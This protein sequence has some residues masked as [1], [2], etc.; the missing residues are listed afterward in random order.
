MDPE[1]PQHSKHAIQ[2]KTAFGSLHTLARDAK[3]MLT[4]ILV[5]DA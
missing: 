2:S 3:A 1:P 4:Y 5:F